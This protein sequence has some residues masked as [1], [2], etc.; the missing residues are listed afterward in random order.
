MI[1][2]KQKGVS[3]IMTFF[4]MVIILS[5]VLA[6]SIILY[7]EIKV[8]RNMGNS[9]VS[10]YAADS[11]IEKVLYYDRQ[12]IPL[13]STGV[14]CTTQEDC[15]PD[16]ICDSDS[17]CKTSAKRGLCA[18]FDSANNPKYCAEGNSDNGIYCNSQSKV[19]ASGYGK[20]CDINTCENCQISFITT[21]DNRK[22]TT[23]AK[24]YP[25]DSGTFIDSYFAITS[26]GVFPLSGGAQ[27]QIYILINPL[28]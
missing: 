13:I 22:Y 5:V 19:D 7:S 3:L 18:M 20:G 2:D 11:G 9:V 27:R 10:L 15:G 25:D 23:T 28:E 21:F 1:T 12:A 4:I 14:N 16:Q 26:K 24:V 6:I 17:F 8:I